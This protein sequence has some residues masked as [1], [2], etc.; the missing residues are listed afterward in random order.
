MRATGARHLKTLWQ[1]RDKS[2]C[3]WALKYGHAQHK[4]FVWVDRWRWRFHMTPIHIEYWENTL[5]VGVCVG[6][7][8]LYAM[9]H[10]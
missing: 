5:E 10:H 6:R 4:R 1:D 9:R 8:T 3:W 2:W 7:R